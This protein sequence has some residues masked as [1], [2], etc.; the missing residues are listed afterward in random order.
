MSDVYQTKLKPYAHQQ[1]ALDKMQGRAAFAL[2]MGMRTGKT[3][4]LLDDYGRLEQQGLCHSLMVIAPGGVYRTWRTQIEDHVSAD[5]LARLV[6]HVWESGDTKRARVERAVF[7]KTRDRPRI[8]LMNVEALSSVKAARELAKEFLAQDPAMLAIDESTIIKGH[9]SKRT[10]FILNELS[11][12]APWRR[13]LSGLPSPRSPMDLYSQFEFLDWKILGARSW[14]AFRARYAVLKPAFFG[15]R[16][17]LQIDGYQ[18]LDELQ[19]KIEPHS[20]RVLLEDCYD[21]PAKS[22][23]MREVSLTPEQQRLYNE[24][25]DFA[26]TQL[27]TEEHVTATVVIAQINKLH[28]ILCGHAR[29]EHGQLHAVPERRTEA[30]LELLEE[31]DGKAIVWC[32]YDADVQ[33]LAAALTKE[34]GPGSVARFWGGNVSTREDE[35]RMF[36]TLPGCRFMVATPAAG[37]RGR[38]WSVAGLVVY[39]SNSDNLEHRDQSEER[40]QAIGKRDQVTYI[41][42]VAPK[43]VD[44]KIIASLRA[45]I[46]LASAVTGD[47]WREWLV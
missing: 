6:V 20:F 45:K 34:Y 36:R 14:F 2:L 24:M 17:I 32:S 43:T 33:K 9:T 26:T 13:I 22:Y 4:V 15:G 38:E 30:L 18:N 27:A 11:P 25:R 12:L 39:F 21:V 1:R 16:Q 8:L 47:A 37:G 46:D 3:K 35:E 28:Q 41:D 7:L 31:Y 10:K 5:L 42:L 44:E 23:A 19:R 40:S 29:D